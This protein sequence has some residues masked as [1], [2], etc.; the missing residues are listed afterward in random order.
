VDMENVASSRNNCD[1]LFLEWLSGVTEIDRYDVGNVSVVNEG[2]HIRV[3]MIGA[4]TS[5]YSCP[6]IVCLL[7]VC[8]Q[9]I[10]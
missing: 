6:Q 5:V 1:R 9:L 2:L 4:K 8:G 10:A 3:Y 7:H